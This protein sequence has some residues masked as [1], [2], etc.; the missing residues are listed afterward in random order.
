PR[1]NVLSL[2]DA[3]RD[4]ATARADVSLLLVGEGALR[5]ELHARRDAYHLQDRVFIRPFVL[6]AILPKYYALADVFVLPSVYDTFGVVVA[7][8]M[9]CGLPIVTTPTVGATSSIVVDNEN[10]LLVE[11]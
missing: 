9:A 2:L 3:F 4:L 8:A 10:G 6:Q 7:E 5:A 1:E 11:A